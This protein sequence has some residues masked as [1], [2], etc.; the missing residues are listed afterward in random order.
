MY[1][2]KDQVSHFLFVFS[3]MLAVTI[4]L[5]QTRKSEG[6]VVNTTLQDNHIELTKDALLAAL[7]HPNSSVRSA[8]ALRLAV[9]GE[10][11]AIPSILEAL[12]IET[13]PGTRMSLASAA[14]KLGAEE[15]AVALKNM[16]GDQS[17]SAV[18]RM[19]AAWAM[20]VESREDCLGNV[21]EVIRFHDDGQATSQALNLLTWFKRAP[22]GDMQEVR[23]LVRMSLRSTDPDVRM[24]ASYVLRK[25]GD[26]SA[27]EDVRSALAVEHDETAREVLA[28]DLKA[29]QENQANSPAK[30]K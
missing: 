21:L 3:F 22:V 28:R 13:F 10:K 20:L 9:N 8:S 16:C 17:W 14:M 25:W 2:N 26:S 18:L 6:R 29:L 23:N 15:G 19:S 30:A 12:A 7:R 11:D 4:S 27:M 5:A 24:K 1:R